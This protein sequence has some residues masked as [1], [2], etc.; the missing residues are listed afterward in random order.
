[1]KSAIY[2]PLVFLILT[3]SHEVLSQKK[4]PA[5]PSLSETKKWITEKLSLY[6]EGYESNSTS[7]NVKRIYLIK[8]ISSNETDLIIEYS[9]ELNNEDF[10]TANSIITYNIPW[11][12]FKSSD[13]YKIIK[14]DNLDLPGTEL[15]GDYLL[16]ITTKANLINKRVSN[17]TKKFRLPNGTVDESTIP[18]YNMVAKESIVSLR[19]DS[20]P[21]LMSRLLKAFNVLCV[22]NKPKSEAY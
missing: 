19:L 18:D 8:S 3:L 21:N 1:M 20:E 6:S 22:Y 9:M 14:S 11:K 13:N 17:E 16:V 4:A 5:K 15:Y 2:L 7:P 12:I 10:L